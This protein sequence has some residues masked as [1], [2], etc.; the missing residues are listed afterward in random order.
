M[1]TTIEFAEDVSLNDF[2]DFIVRFHKFLLEEE[3]KP[4]IKDI[5]VN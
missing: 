3:N 4:L 2:S 1:D 5:R